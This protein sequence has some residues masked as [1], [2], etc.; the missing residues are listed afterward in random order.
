M[1]FLICIA[2][3]AKGQKYPLTEPETL[4]GRK[5][6]QGIRLEDTKASSQH[7]RIILTSVGAEIED[8]QSSNG[9]FIN[10]ARIKRIELQSGDR[11]VIGAHVLEFREDRP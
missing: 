6:A 5:V 11:L 8:L 2:G 3:P 7:C 1:K 10:G 9:T 4:I